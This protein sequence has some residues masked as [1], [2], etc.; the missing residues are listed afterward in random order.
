MSMR[1]GTSF[2]ARVTVALMVLVV[3]LSA[4]VVAVAAP[5]AA[6]LRMLFARHGRY[7]GTGVDEVT[8]IELAN[9]FGAYDLIVGAEFGALAPRREFGWDATEPSR[10]SFN[11]DRSDPVV[12]FARRYGQTLVGNGLLG[13]QGLPA[14]VGDADLPPEQVRAMMTGHVATVV[15]HFRGA[16]ARWDV[17]TTPFEDD[18][19]LRQTPFAMA[20][21]VGYIADA[22]VAARAADPQA[23]LYL[24]VQGLEGSAASTEAMLGLASSLLARGVPLD[25]VG[26]RGRFALGAVPGDLAATMRRFTDLGLEVALDEVEVRIAY[27][28][29]AT[30]LRRQAEEYTAIT[31]A[32]L[33]VERCVGID[34]RGV[35]DTESDVV[36]E[37]PGS[38]LS[39]LLDNEFNRKPGYQGMVVG[40]GGR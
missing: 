1:V 29:D 5:D 9:S 27:P 21:G 20:L 31:R 35:R 32:C 10:G 8:L 28:A 23:K 40:L 19:T 37:Y 26:L 14:W 33:M 3:M 36:F 15:G 7:L 16:V 24:S 25:G 2:T 18:G 13:T 39:L 30:K 11:F 22:L 38:G 4:A 6:T 17:V 34:L 12:W